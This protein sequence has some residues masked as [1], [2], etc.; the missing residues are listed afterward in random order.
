[1]SINPAPLGNRRNRK[2]G[3]LMYHQGYFVPKNVEKYIGNTPILYRS[4]W[5][6]AFCRFCDLNENIKK[7][8]TE[9]LGISYQIRNNNNQLVDHKYIPDFYIEMTSSSDSEKYE[10]L[11]IEIKPKSETL[12]PNPPKKE[13]LKALESYKYSLD[14]FKQNLQ[15][16]S[17]AKEWCNKR[18]MKFIIITEDDLKK[19]GLIS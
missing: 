8:S 2:N 11:L 5:E 3:K 15:K 7:W 14:T 16:W 10:R 18:N 13:T 17:Y 9:S 1:M 12:H 6:L 19:R 4:S